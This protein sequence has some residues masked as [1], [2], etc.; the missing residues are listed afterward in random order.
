MVTHEHN[1]VPFDP[2]SGK[3]SLS[4]GYFRQFDFAFEEDSC[5]DLKLA[6][7]SP[8]RSVGSGDI[9]APAM[10]AK[11]WHKLGP[12]KPLRSFERPLNSERAV[13]DECF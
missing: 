10:A 7:N 5:R 2:K 11:S 9:L 8:T 13:P 3:A 6:A 4:S 1:S 12:D